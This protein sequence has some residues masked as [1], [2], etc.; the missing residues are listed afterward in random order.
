[1]IVLF[2]YYNLNIF[3]EK[4]KSTYTLRLYYQSGRIDTKTFVLPKNSTLSLIAK[5]RSDLIS[6][7][8]I[9]SKP[10]SN[11]FGILALGVDDYEIIN[12]K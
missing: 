2:A 8:Y 5:S 3:P 11:E 1:M 12:I 9:R 6:L 10:F 7:G 4:E